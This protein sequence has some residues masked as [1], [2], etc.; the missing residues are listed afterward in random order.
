MVKVRIERLMTDSHKKTLAF[1]FRFTDMFPDKELVRGIQA[2]LDQIIHTGVQ[3]IVKLIHRTNHLEQA[4]DVAATASATQ[5]AAEAVAA[6][7]ERAKTSGKSAS[8]APAIRS[9]IGL[10]EELNI[11]R[12]MQLAATTENNSNSQ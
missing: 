10:D 11:E 5:R 12:E 4:K 8:N 2:E 6:A 9:I 7:N 1:S 3:N